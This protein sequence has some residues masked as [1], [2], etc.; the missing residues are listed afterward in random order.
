M[1]FNYTFDIYLPTDSAEEP[2][3]NILNLRSTREDLITFLDA[4]YHTDDEFIL[5]KENIDKGN[6]PCFDKVA[7]PN[8]LVIKTTRHHHLLQHYLSISENIHIVSIVRH[9]C[10]IINSWI[11]SE[12]EFANKGCTIVDDWKNGR[13]RKGEEGEFWG[14]DDW[15][16]V[17]KIHLELCRKTK[18]FCVIRYSDLVKDPEKIIKTL[19]SDIGLMLGEQT[20]TFLKQCHESHNS[21]SYSVFKSMDV[22]HKW[23]H[24]LDRDITKVIIRETKENN[25]EEFLL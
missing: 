5:Q 13:C 14:F 18:R 21:D 6:Y 2:F 12:R 19:F 4:V 23:K 3:K 10:A 1:R 9:P 22:E 25:L 7:S 8:T 20:L 11:Q 24:E 17:T 15:V 16:A